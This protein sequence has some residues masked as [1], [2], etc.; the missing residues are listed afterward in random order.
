MKLKLSRS[1]GNHTAVLAIALLLAALWLLQ[2]HHYAHDLDHHAAEC[3]FCVKSGTAKPMLPVVDSVVVIPFQSIQ[4]AASVYIGLGRHV[5][6][7]YFAR[8][9]PYTFFS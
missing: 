7:H 4:T 8:A 3:E 2:S 6:L 5:V 1:Q 9:P